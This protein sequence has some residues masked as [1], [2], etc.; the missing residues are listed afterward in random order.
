VWEAKLVEKHACGLHSFNGRDLSVKLE[1]VCVHV[2]GVEDERAVEARELSALVIE[3][4]N[5]L[6]HLRMLPIRDILE[7]LGEERAFEAS[8]WD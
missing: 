2:T 4:S 7:H 6:V 3:A 5:T 8:P 1:E